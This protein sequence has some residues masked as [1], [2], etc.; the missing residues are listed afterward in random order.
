MIEGF[1]EAL[2][3]CIATAK[4]RGMTLS[5][6]Y[7]KFMLN[8]W[9]KRNPSLTT[10]AGEL[11]KAAAT[12]KQTLSSVKVRSL[13]GSSSLSRHG[14]QHGSIGP[15]AA[16]YSRH[17]RGVCPPQ[18][19][20]SEPKQPKTD[21]STMIED[22][23]DQK[24]VEDGSYTSVN[25]TTKNLHANQ[26]DSLLL[27]V[28]VG[29]GCDSLAPRCPHYDFLCYLT[30]ALC[31]AQD[32]VARQMTVLCVSNQCSQEPGPPSAHQ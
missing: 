3:I 24:F 32:V 2:D 1:Q 15:D 22:S 27:G 21:Q 31:P 8:S 26:L 19:T 29:S 11:L 30:N 10:G 20:K 18:Q 16:Y 28:N 13:R 25:D 14:V 12:S 23:P 7:Q 17:L 4:E 9:S 6:F 5:R